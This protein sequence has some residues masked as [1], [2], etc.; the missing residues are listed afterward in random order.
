MATGLIKAI[1]QLIKAIPQIIEALV[2]GFME[3]RQKFN[4]I[5]EN[6]VDGIWNGISS[7]W[8]WL[9]DKVKGIAGG[10]VDAA[11][12]AL[13]IHSPSTKFKYLGEMCVAGFDEGVDDLFDTD[14]LNKSI[15]ASFGTLSANVKYADAGERPSGIDVDGIKSA[16]AAG[17]REG[18][19]SADIK[20]YLSGK[21]VSQGVDK[22]LGAAEVTKGRY[23]T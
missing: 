4:E 2:K 20:T 14:T 21:K 11:K 23:G 8:N 6:I 17:A 18:I 13:G 7:G 9:V 10:L 22:E 5:G 1:P 16:V 12:S 3:L 15:N 19:E